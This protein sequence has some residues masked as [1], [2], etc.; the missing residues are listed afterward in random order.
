MTDESNN[1]PEEG[2]LTDEQIAEN[3]PGQDVTH[4]RAM[5]DKAAGIGSPVSPNA[6]DNTDGD[7]A[8]DMVEYPTYIPEKY[9]QGTID[10]AHAAMAA[11]HAELESKL[12]SPEGEDDGEGED[13]DAG[14]ESGAE[15]EFSLEEVEAEYIS[16]DGEISE[17]TYAAAEKAGMSRAV[18][19]SYIAG[20]QAIANQLVS[21]VHE[22]AGGEENYTSMLTWATN[23]WSEAEV[24]AFD[25]VMET[26]NETQINLTVRGLKAAFEADNGKAPN[27]TKGDSGSPTPDGA[28]QSKAEMTAA[29]KDPRYKTDPAYRDSVARK[30]S[31]SDIW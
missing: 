21:R 27:L 30:L 17:A 23:N 7:N 2:A 22:A 6:D 24:S 31:N 4:I 14:A 28:F 5:L 16:A 26:G 25:A 12:G 29:M 10:E 18:V 19:D 15:G 13:D 8:D 1:T 3:F 11:G 9:R 20:Q